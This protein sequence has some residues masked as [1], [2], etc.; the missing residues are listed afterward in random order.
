MATSFYDVVVI[1]DELAGAVAAAHL[2]R[3][4]FRVLVL[5]SAPVERD[6]VGPWTVP[7]APMALAGL[8]GPA[9]KRLVNELSL[10]QLLRR[11][12]EPN[13]PLMQ[14]LLPDHR[15]DVTGDEL[16]RELLRELPEEAAGWDQYAAGAAAISRTLDTLLVEDVT[17]PPD[18]FW[19]RRDLKRMAAQLPAGEGEPQL[20]P[21]AKMLALLPALFTSDLMSPG[22]IP[23]ARLTDQLAHGTFRLDGGREGLRAMLLERVRTWAGEVRFDVGARSL[24][25]RRNRVTGVALGI[26]DEQVG[27]NQVIAAMPAAELV[28][29]LEGSPPR[30]L[31]EA[32]AIAA[33]LHRYLVH[34]VVPIEALPDALGPL[35]YAARD[36]DAPPEDGNMLA[37]HV[38]QDQHAVLSVEALAAD[39]RPEALA[40]LRANVLEHLASLLPFLERHLLAVWSPHDGLPADGLANAVAQPPAPMDAIWHLPAP[41]ALGFCGL[42]HA[43]GIKQAW[44]ASRQQLPGLG[45][46]GELIA[47]WGAARLAAARDKRRVLDKAELLSG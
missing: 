44:F 18:G 43:T 37:I 40:R 5:C 30:R 8:E 32:A 16:H 24:L 38:A 39:T 31:V 4:G 34:L 7:H 14:L 21:R 1:G 11:R 22:R 19:D 13:H 47:G 25:L 41:R 2:A 6:H 45:F 42:P 33:P 26:R 9:L 20:G 27:C 17:L 28:E 29:L 12:V 15:L 23:L 10:L 35:A 46:E 3:R 36:L